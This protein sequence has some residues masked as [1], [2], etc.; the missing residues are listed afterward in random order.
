M[1]AVRR[2][3]LSRFA[4]QSLAGWP[5]MVCSQSHLIRHIQMLHPFQGPDWGL[6]LFV[7]KGVGGAI[8]GSETG[9][10]ALWLGEKVVEQ[11]NRD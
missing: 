9:R 2:F 5:E 10:L 6:F 3:R 7:S 8:R 1:R 11:N 4:S